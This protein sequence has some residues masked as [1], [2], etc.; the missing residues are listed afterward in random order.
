M[1]HEST[2]HQTWNAQSINGAYNVHAITLLSHNN[3]FQ[4]HIRE[5]AKFI[6]L[7]QGQRDGRGAAK[8][9]WE[10]KND[11]ANTFSGKKMMGQG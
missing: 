5:G 1:H 3:K 6:G 10:E 8:S 4:Y 11:R 2:K 9:F 7:H